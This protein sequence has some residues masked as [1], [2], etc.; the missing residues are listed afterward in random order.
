MGGRASKRVLV[1][2]TG[3]ASDDAPSKLQSPSFRE[4][5]FLDFCQKD[6]HRDSEQNPYRMTSRSLTASPFV[7]KLIFHS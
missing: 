1:L 7:K 6:A 5:H 4:I 2:I 3:E